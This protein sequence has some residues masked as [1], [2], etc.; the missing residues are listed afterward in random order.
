MN[1]RLLIACFFLCSALAVFADPG[2]GMVM[3]SKGNLFYTDLKQVWMIRADGTKSIAVPNVHTHELYVDAQDRLYGEHL[4][5]NGEQLNT[6]GHYVWRHQANGV[7]ERIK[8]STAGFLEWYSFTRDGQGNQYYLE[9]SIPAQFWKLDVAGKKTLLA[10]K[11]WSGLGRLHVTAKGVLLFTHKGDV[12]AIPPD[13]S[14]EL[15]VKNA[16]ELNPVL[17]DS[18]VTIWNIWS[19]S[20]RNMYIATGNVIKKIDHRRLVTTIYQSG[21]GWYPVSGY[22][23]ATG[24][25]W[26]MEYNTANEVRVNKI[27]AEER[28]EIAAQSRWKMFYMPLLLTAA[29]VVLLYF[30]FRS[31]KKEA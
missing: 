19:D 23:S 12:Y 2:V 16:G 25:F 14:L 1:L 9:K 8:D 20:R 18:S 4:W 6:W 21:E 10:S 27:S 11:S 13:D 3:D 24:D 31:K 22:V 7:M 30:L 29:I 28:K 15:V 26:V 5:Y 17:N